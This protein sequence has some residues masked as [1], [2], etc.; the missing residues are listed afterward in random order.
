MSKIRD[1]E[2]RLSEWDRRILL[3]C[4][5]NGVLEMFKCAL[6]SM[7]HT[8]P[9]DTHM[10]FLQFLGER[11]CMSVP[12]E[13]QQDFVRQFGGRVDLYQACGIVM[14]VLLEDPNTPRHFVWIK[15]LKKAKA[16]KQPTFFERRSNPIFDAALRLQMPSRGREMPNGNLRRRSTD[17]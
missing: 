17:R 3:N 11:K 8:V 15:A 1:L 10:Y 14:V 5:T 4:R 13:V 12:I 7:S 2:S 6:A 16:Q 9:K